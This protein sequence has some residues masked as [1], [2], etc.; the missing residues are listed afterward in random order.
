MPY[1][2]LVSTIFG[3]CLSFT[4]QAAAP[5]VAVDIAP[6][7]SLVSQVMEGVGTPTLIIPAE[8][9]PHQY[10]LRPSQARALSNA[11]VVFWMGE[12]YTPWLEKAMDNVATGAVKVEMLEVDGTT[13][14]SFREGVTFEVHDHEEH[15]AHEGHE[16]EESQAAHEGHEHNDEHAAHE[17]HE[18]H[19]EHAAHEGHEGHEEHASHEGHE[20]HAAHEGHEDHEEHAAHEGHDHHGADPH[21]W[22]D[23]QNAKVWIVAIQ[24][25]LSKQDPANKAVYQS[26]ANKALAKLDTLIASTDKSIDALGKVNFVVFHD[27]YQYFEKRFD[28][29]ASGSIS[30]SDAQDPSPAR[31]K[32]VKNTVEKLSVTCV[33]TEPQFNPGMVNS[34]FEGTQV[35]AIAVMDPLGV[36]IPLGVGHYNA[37]IE[38]MVLSLQTCK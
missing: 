13:I 21:A 17:N 6:L 4:V 35:S 11:D 33:F 16:I 8:A 5:K 18:D 31:I 19:E 34:V 3:L 30:L 10:T 27:A 22:L 38:N 36:D 7:H 24:E 20:E 23:P 2:L 9:S 26:N 28:I 32:E 14:Y 25:T 15:A 12:S 1:K 37:L 29:I